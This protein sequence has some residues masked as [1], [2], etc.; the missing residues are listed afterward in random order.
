[1]EILKTTAKSAPIPTIAAFVAYTVLPKLIETDISTNNLIIIS[2]LTFLVIF[3]VLFYG[4][5]SKKPQSHAS[6]AISGNEASDLE[7][8]TGDIFIG[9]K[10]SSTGE[11]SNNKIT[12]AKTKKGDIFIGRKR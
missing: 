3:S 7:T 10:S 9:D 4:I 5:A 8:E 6:D 1:M 2:I 12:K 11:I